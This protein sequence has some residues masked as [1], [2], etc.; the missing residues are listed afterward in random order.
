MPYDFKNLRT[1][2]VS[3]GI[4][5]AEAAHIF[6]T[7]RTTLYSWCAGNAPN[8][9]LLLVNTTRLIRVIQ[10]A[11]DAGDL[12]VKGVAFKEDRINEITK[13]LKRHLSG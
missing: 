11:L 5:I 10:K 2:L 7:S 8:Q 4:T 9:E 1:L 3:A 13:V 6:K 12:P